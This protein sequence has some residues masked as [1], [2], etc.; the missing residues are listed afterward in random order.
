VPAK[1]PPEIIVTIRNA[2]VAAMKAPD[3][4]KRM[5]ETASQPVGTT[6]EQFGAFLKSEVDSIAA[7]VKRLK[8]SAD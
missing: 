8:L 6:P 7:L 3:V 5:F 1:T 4:S 2:A